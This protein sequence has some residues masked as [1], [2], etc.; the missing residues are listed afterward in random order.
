M[1]TT[2][3][4]IGGGGRE[5]A[6]VRQLAASPLRP[7]LLA[8]PGNPGIATLAGDVALDVRDH[9][10]V[11]RFCQNEGVDLVVVGPE[12]PLIAGLADHLRHGGVAVFGPGAM[13]ARLEGDKEFAKEVLRTAGV[14]TSH[15]Q[16][17]SSS[18][19][20]LDHLDT[21]DLHVVVKACGAAQG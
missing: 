3:L 18:E 19:T 12:E 5:H 10:A 15:A 6:I 9:A 2:V 21:M 16:A 20:A 1:P 8:A 11:V 17:F 13:G 4:V 14:P 7:R